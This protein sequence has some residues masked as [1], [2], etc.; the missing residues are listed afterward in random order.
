MICTLQ[1]FTNE[2]LYKAF[3][4]QFCMPALGKDDIGNL[5][6]PFSIEEIK[7]AVHSLQNSKA[8]GPNGFPSEVLR[9]LPVN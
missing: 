8:P 5:D 9:N 4:S 2:T 7:D 3:F 6:K 1:S